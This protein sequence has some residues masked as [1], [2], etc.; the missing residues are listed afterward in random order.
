MAFICQGVAFL[1]A[2]ARRALDKIYLLVFV[3][4]FKLTSL[5]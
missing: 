5:E 2:Q 1:I 3:V 4:V